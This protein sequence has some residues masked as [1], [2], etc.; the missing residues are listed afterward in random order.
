MSTRVRVDI[1][2][3]SHPGPPKKKLLERN[4]NAGPCDGSSWRR[5]RVIVTR[6]SPCSSRGAASS[7]IVAGLEVLSLTA[8]HTRTYLLCL[9]G[10]LWVFALLSASNLPKKMAEGG[11]SRKPLL[12]TRTA[13]ELGES[14]S[15]THART[16]KAQIIGEE[17]FVGD[18]VPPLSLLQT[19]VS[20]RLQ[21][22]KKSGQLSS[23]VRVICEHNELEAAAICASAHNGQGK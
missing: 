12:L 6:S 18:S 17:D 3:I 1:K 20:S 22:R 16:H 2:L 4:Q 21:P 7:I 10:N 5:M 9:T 15:R 14:L 13:V 23:W 19:Q 11:L 8:A